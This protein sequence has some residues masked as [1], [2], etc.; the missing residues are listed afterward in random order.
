V[1][2]TVKR[3]RF[4]RREKSDAQGKKLLT[5]R[6]PKEHLRTEDLI[7]SRNRLV[8]LLEATW[9]DS[10]WNLETLRGTGTRTDVRRALQIWD[11]DY[12]RE[13]FVVKMLLRPSSEDPPRTTKLKAMKN[14]MIQLRRAIQDASDTRQQHLNLLNRTKSAFAAELRKEQRDLL[15]VEIAKLEKYIADEEDRY[16]SMVNSP[17]ALQ[18]VLFDGYASFAQEQLLDFLRKPR[19]RLTP[20]RIANALAGLPFIGWR[21]SAKRCVKRRCEN[22]NGLNYRVHRFIGQIVAS[23]PWQTD[24]I[25]HARKMTYRKRQPDSQVA[26]DLQ[27]NWPSLEAAIETVLNTDHERTARV[28]KIASEYFRRVSQPTNIDPIVAEIK[29]IVP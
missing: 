5:R 29:S 4:K 9:C 19:Y 14:Q 2:V 26:S 15:S 16:A 21:Q 22:A 7:S 24:L 13:E 28:Y 12:Y 27:R 3:Q 8:S 23:R 17:A 10:I 18:E 1:A 11:L 6:G 20:E 25:E